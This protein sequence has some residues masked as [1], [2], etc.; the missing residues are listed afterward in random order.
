MPVNVPGTTAWSNVQSPIAGE[1][2]SAPAL[3]STTITPLVNRTNYLKNITEPH[4]GTGVERHKVL[5]DISPAYNSLRSITGMTTG[6]GFWVQ[7][8]ATGSF[9]F[10]VYDASSGL[11]ERVPDVIRSGTGAWINAKR[12]PNGY[13][14][15]CV[16]GQVEVTAFAMQEISSDVISPTSL[17]FFTGA[18]PSSIAFPTAALGQT[19][20]IVDCDI[21]VNY[22]ARFSGSQQLSFFVDFSLDGSDIETVAD[23]VLGQGVSGYTIMPNNLLLDIPQ[24]LVVKKRFFYTMASA[25]LT[26]TPYLVANKSLGMPANSPNAAFI[27]THEGI[28]PNRCVIN[29]SRI[30]F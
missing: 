1:V 10:F 8:S 17:D 25:P 11:A 22:R 21:V 26:L 30:F 15:H 13:L 3:N 6:D 28:M 27:R 16:A 4:T 14:E 2:N 18:S 12:N 29:I 23:Y 7:D 19:G 9:D 24:Q 5:S 20:W